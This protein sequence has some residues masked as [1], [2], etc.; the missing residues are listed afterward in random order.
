MSKQPLLPFAVALMVG[1]VVAHGLGCSPWFW[2]AALGVVAL[3]IGICFLV[4]KRR[5][6][7]AICLVLLAFTLG[8]WRGAASDPSLNP[9]HYTHLSNGFTSLTLR[10]TSSPE[11]RGKTL[12][13]KAEVLSVAGCPSW[14]II[15][16]YL[17]PDSLASPLRYGDLLL[18]NAAPDPIQHRVY[19]TP[20]RY[21]LLSR[22]STS[23]RAH[24]ERL[25]MH[26]LH[27]MQRGGMTHIGVAE[28]LVLGWKAD[29]DEATQGS[30]RNA[31]I[32]HLLAVSGLHVGL[33]AAIA[34]CLLFWVSRTRRGR[35]IRGVG[36]LLAVWTFTFLTG[37]APS[38]LRAA[39]MFSLFIVANVS[40]RRTEKLNLLATAAIAMLVASPMLIFDLGW[41]LS[42]AAVG[43]ILLAMPAIRVFRSKVLSSAALSVS[44][45][46]ATLP[47]IL[48]AFH[49]VPIYF[50]LANVVVVPYAALLLAT[51]LLY[52]LLPV[53][54]ISTVL[55]AMLTAITWFTSWVQRLPYAVVENIEVSPWQ[56]VLVAFISLTMLLFPRW[57][58]AARHSADSTPID[59]SFLMLDE[60]GD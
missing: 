58:L 21:T 37:L 51:S 28:A 10:L 13:A 36:Q 59:R 33:V 35:I 43:G 5:E 23:L 52:L 45:T 1:V 4:V 26:L 6:T 3:C 44:A 7:V 54:P 46:L 39:L 11:P 55:D 12:R 30:F 41:Q 17:I 32:A 38:T 8:A 56:T 16:A 27:R 20:N 53:A 9:T 15:T 47:I 50:L 24:C 60:R 57:L 29:I 49:R 2:L 19:A 25:R 42:F 31:G 22:D 48:T 40:S 18:L 14:G 34:G